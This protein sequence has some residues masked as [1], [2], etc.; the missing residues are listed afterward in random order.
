MAE[1]TVRM[2]GVTA[3]P[4][5]RSIKPLQNQYTTALSSSIGRAPSTTTRTVREGNY[6]VTYR[7]GVQVSR[8]YSPVAA[9]PGRTPTTSATTGK[10]STGTSK[11]APAGT[12]GAISMAKT[13]PNAT[14]VNAN[15][16]P[17]TG[18]T[19]GAGTTGGTF[20]D[21]NISER[22]PYGWTKNMSEE[23]MDLGLAY[24]P[25]IMEQVMGRPISGLTQNAL[26]PYIDQASN[27]WLQ[28]MMSQ[29]LGTGTGIT[30]SPDDDYNFRANFMKNAIT[31]GGARVDFQEALRVLAQGMANPSSAIWGGLMA[32]ADD[33]SNQGGVN[34]AS[35]LFKNFTDALTAASGGLSNA[36][37][38]G[39]SGLMPQW[40]DQYLKNFV[41]S[42]A[43]NVDPLTYLMRNIFGISAPMSRPAAPT[44]T[45]LPNL[46]PFS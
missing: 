30:S 24:N 25:R 20:G 28:L 18:G 14:V 42:A 33:P 36:S 22:S 35:L 27:P 7:N 12:I 13:I 29:G 31:P 6:L 10:L 4:A 32:G 3:L 21:A 17:A 34:A 15:N 23:V 38:L 1:E 9:P 41:P 43:G 40:Q 37:L 19:G 5:V 45:G 8:V 2:P 16:A 11:T 26:L 44:G 46:N 39:L